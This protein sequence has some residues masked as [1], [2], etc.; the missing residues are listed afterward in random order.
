MPRPV[1]TSPKRKRRND[2]TK[3]KRQVP[4]SKFESKSQSGARTHRTP[5]A[6][7][8]KFRN[9]QPAF[10]KLS[11]CVRVRSSLSTSVKSQRHFHS[12]VR[13]AHLDTA[14]GSNGAKLCG[15]FALVACD[16]FRSAMRDNGARHALFFTPGELRADRRMTDQCFA[17]PANERAR[18]RGAVA[19]VNSNAIQRSLAFV[20][21]D[22]VR[23][24]EDARTPC[25]HSVSDRRGGNG[26]FY[27]ERFECDP[28]NFRRRTFFNYGAMFDRIVL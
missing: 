1:I 18:E 27:R 20:N 21:K 14:F 7:R 9:A 5:K 10:A 4:T 24:V 6:L 8:A 17:A 15:D 3:T 11:E 16:D 2:M 26:M 22:Q 25:I 12:I 28:T 23:R 19:D 13:D